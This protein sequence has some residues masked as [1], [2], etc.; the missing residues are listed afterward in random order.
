MSNGLGPHKSG[1]PGSCTKT[2]PPF[3][4]WRFSESRPG[5]SAPVYQTIWES[6]GH[7]GAT[8]LSMGHLHNS[9]SHRPIE[10]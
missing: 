10:T 2:G 1:R 8:C 7:T 4:C 6:F 3:E 9:P 5:R